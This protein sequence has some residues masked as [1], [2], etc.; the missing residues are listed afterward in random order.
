[1]LTSNDTI[2]MNGNLFEFNPLSQENIVQV[3]QM[4]EDNVKLVSHSL[5]TFRET[6]LESD[7][8][9]PH[10][11]IVVS[12]N[13]KEFIA[14]FMVVLRKSLILKR[15]RKV[16]VLKFFV[17]KKSWRNN[18]IGSYL[19][20]QLT[21][22]IKN[23][24]RKSFRMKFEVMSSTPDYLYPGLNPQHT[25]AFFFLKK[26]GFKKTSQR[27]NLCLSLDNLDLQKPLKKH[28]NYNIRR[29][30]IKDK[31][32]LINLKFMSKKYQ[33]GFWPEEIALTFKKTP[34]TTFI[35]QD[36]NTEDILGWASHS[37]QFPGSFGPTGVKKNE[38][39]K[40]MGTMLLKW[41]LWDLKT[42]FKLNKVKINWV[43][44]DTAYFYSKSVGAYICEFF[45]TMKKRF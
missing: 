45:W 20:N 28:K 44:E 25:E 29:A 10:L 8:F 27:I 1:L 32:K 13:K 22:R 26:H 14:F 15:L 33:L 38:R 43:S 7:L 35:A 34:I 9:N 16:A 21:E 4:C 18:G 19:L 37:V 6:T 17:V 36:V 42:N 11:S 23:S 5:D 24:E 39:G 31:K 3:H 30:E 40:G 41:C 2:P 12:T